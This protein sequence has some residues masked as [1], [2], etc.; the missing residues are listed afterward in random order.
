MITMDDFPNPDNIYKYS[1]PPWFK[2]HYNDDQKDI[3]RSFRDRMLD[4][5]DAPEDIEPLIIKIRGDA[6]PFIRRIFIDVMEDNPMLFKWDVDISVVDRGIYEIV[7]TPIGK[8]EDLQEY[9]TKIM[10]RII[11]VRDEYQITPAMSE[12]DIIRCVNKWLLK[13]KYLKYEEPFCHRALGIMLKG[14]GVCAS[15]AAANHILLN[16]FGVECY[17]VSGRVNPRTKECVVMD[18]GGYIDSTGRN[19]GP[20]NTCKYSENDRIQ[21]DIVVRSNPSQRNVKN[22]NH[23]WNVVGV[24]GYL[25]QSDPTFNNGHGNDEYLIRTIK[26]LND[27]ISNKWNKFAEGREIPLSPYFRG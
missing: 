2:N 20:F 22:P 14:E 19:L 10:K 17:T 5:Y 18:W 16:S 26:G 23:A 8:Q 1:M 21:P 15:F 9:E 27:R 4:A 24:G 25:F 7:F 3:Y 12:L 13:K 11:E 6:Y